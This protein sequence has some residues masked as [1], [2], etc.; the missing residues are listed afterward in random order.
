[1][2]LSC[3]FS[4][5][6]AMNELIKEGAIPALLNQRGA[7]TKVRRV[8]QLLLYL[9]SYVDADREHCWHSSS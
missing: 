6:V 1:M 4:G 2:V 3:P 9:E 5:L 7:D 8:Q